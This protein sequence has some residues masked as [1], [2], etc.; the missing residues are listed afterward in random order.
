MSGS[1]NSGQGNWA[2]SSMVEALTAMGAMIVVYSAIL[3]V[4]VTLG[5]V[6]IGGDTEAEAGA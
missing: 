3:W 5:R 1:H 6:L 2:S 4:I